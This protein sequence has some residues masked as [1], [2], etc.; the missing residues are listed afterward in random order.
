[1]SRRKVFITGG[2][3]FIGTAITERLVGDC[4]IFIFDNLHR[5]ALKYSSVSNNPHVNLIIGDVLDYNQLLA[6]IDKVG[7]LDWVLHMAAIAGVSTVV[8]KPSLTLKVNLIGTYNV[9]EVLKNRKIQR[10]IDFSTS[11]VYGPTAFRVT[12][13]DA[14]TQGPLGQLRWT[15]A[16]SKLASEYLT[17][18]YNVEF[19][20]PTVS[21]RPFNVY[22]PGQ[23]GEGAIHHFVVNALGGDPLIVH[24]DGNAVRSW[25]FVEDFIDGVCLALESPRAIGEHFNIGNPEATTTVLELAKKIIRLSNSSSKIQYRNCEYPDVE[26]RVPSI[27]KASEYI[28]Y[29]PKIDFDSGVMKTIRWYSNKVST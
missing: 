13:L 27:A 24:G 16:V 14:T 21:I 3:G 15:Y 2:A 20:L 8:N 4:D 29:H 23:I 10:F 25:C 5:N 22:G 28:G 18:S 12:E 26:I 1:M 17:H 11:E 6:T 7:S 9:L 19:G